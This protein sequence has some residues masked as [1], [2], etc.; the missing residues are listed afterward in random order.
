[1]SSSAPHLLG[2][3]QMN[4]DNGKNVETETMTHREV[5]VISSRCLLYCLFFEI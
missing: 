2:T 3:Q 1:M 4:A 5:A